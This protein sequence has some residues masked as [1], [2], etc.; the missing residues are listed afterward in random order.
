MNQAGF[1]IASAGAAGGTL[2][3]VGSPSISIT[4]GS[5]MVLKQSENVLSRVAM[6]LGQMDLQPMGK[7]DGSVASQSTIAS[8]LSRAFDNLCHAETLLNQ[9]GTKL[10]G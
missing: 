5:E 9:L 2:A 3:P 7:S 4:Q 10:F 8:N 6:I 1:G